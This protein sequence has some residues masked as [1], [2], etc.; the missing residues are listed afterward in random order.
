MAL[1]LDCSGQ[2][3]PT[4]EPACLRSPPAVRT[5]PHLC[6]DTPP[7]R[8]RPVKSKT[9]RARTAFQYQCGAAYLVSQSSDPLDLSPQSEP[10]SSD[11]VK[12]LSDVSTYAAGRWRH[13]WLA[14]WFSACC[15]AKETGAHKITSRDLFTVCGFEL[16]CQE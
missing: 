5:N 6:A 2:R 10:L 1:R 7:W 3:S 9:D 12:P 4:T 11:G 14:R 8:C 15:G 13:R 16:A